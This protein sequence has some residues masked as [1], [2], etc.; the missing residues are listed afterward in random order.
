MQLGNTHTHTYTQSVYHLRVQAPS[1]PVMGNST[2][3]TASPAPSPSDHH[4]HQY[5]HHHHH[6]HQQPSAVL[7]KATL[8]A[9]ATLPNRSARHHQHHIGD[10]SQHH[11]QQQ[12]RHHPNCQSTLGGRSRSK[13]RSK[14]GVKSPGAGVDGQPAGG[15]SS[16]VLFL[17]YLI[18]R[19]WNVVVDS[20]DPKSKRYVRLG[21][22]VEL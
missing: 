18:H 7:A 15:E 2:S 4:Q 21:L 17:L 19:T 3:T 1:Q 20:V 14:P 9:S 12:Q 16:R 8:G 5:H 6:H 10:G 13:G 11:H 22:C